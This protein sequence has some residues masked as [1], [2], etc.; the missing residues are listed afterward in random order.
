MTY[1][2]VRPRGSARIRTSSGR[3]EDRRS[4]GRASGREIG[5]DLFAT[6]RAVERRGRLVVV[7]PV[8]VVAGEAR[9]P[10]TGT[11]QLLVRYVERI[12]LHHEA[13]VAVATER[14]VR[15]DHSFVVLGV[16]RATS[17]PA[18][19]ASSR[20]EARLVEPGIRGAGRRGARDKKDME[21]RRPP[22]HR[23][24]HRLRRAPARGVSWPA[25]AAVSSRSPA[26]GT[27][28]TRGLRVR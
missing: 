3:A 15:S 21:L 1:D 10:R 27:H 25:A 19:L 2:F 12:A 7:V 18:E 11:D 6:Q 24:R 5:V 8:E 22:A 20:C 14:A 23:S 9:C 16:A 28:R 26:R 4:I 17:N 13:I